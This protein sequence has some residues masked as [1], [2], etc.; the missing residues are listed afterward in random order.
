MTHSC[1]VGPTC[2]EQELIETNKQKKRLPTS[3]T[4][5]KGRMESGIGDNFSEGYGARNSHVSCGSLVGWLRVLFVSEAGFDQ[6]T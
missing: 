1:E 3:V 4:G 6:G 2:C 5:S